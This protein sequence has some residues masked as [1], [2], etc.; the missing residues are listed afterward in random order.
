MLRVRAAILFVTVTVTVTTWQPHSYCQVSSAFGR[1]LK[2]SGNSRLWCSSQLTKSRTRFYL[3]TAQS[4]LCDLRFHVIKC[5]P[6]W[7]TVYIPYLYAFPPVSY[8]SLCALYHSH[9][10]SKIFLT[11]VK[12]FR[13]STSIFRIQ[14]VCASY[15]VC[16]PYFYGVPSQFRFLLCLLENLWSKMCAPSSRVPPTDLQL[17]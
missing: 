12:I 7:K 5:S 1:H 6:L 10:W 14:N 3:G 15:L 8:S 9:F 4:S 13:S 16:R 11:T 17:L 2:F